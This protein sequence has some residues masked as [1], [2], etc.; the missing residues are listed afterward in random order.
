MPKP[1]LSPLPLP[2]GSSTSGAFSSIFSGSGGGG[3]SSCGSSRRMYRKI[4]VVPKWNLERMGYSLTIR[5]FKMNIQK[6]HLILVRHL[7][8]FTSKF[9]SNLKYQRVHGCD[10]QSIPGPQPLVPQPHHRCDGGQ[11]I[12]GQC[13][14]APPSSFPWASSLAS[15]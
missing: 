14:T 13:S 10:I 6:E 2:L 11:H 1:S 8:R 12:L 7:S 3:G 15:P 9:P 4:G 5:T